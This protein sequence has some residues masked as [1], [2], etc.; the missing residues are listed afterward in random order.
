MDQSLPFLGKVALV[1]GS[2]RGIG[3]A[4]ALRLAQAGADLV[5]NYLKNQVPA[6]EVAAQVRE[7]GR[8][9]IVVQANVAKPDDIDT[10]FAEIEVEFGGLIILLNNSASGCNR[11]AVHLQGMAWDGTL[12]VHKRAFQ[13]GPPREVHLT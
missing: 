3:K 2:G 8:R 1:T 11:P 13:M 6:E 9:A 12:H 5:I 7:L 10:L 4:I